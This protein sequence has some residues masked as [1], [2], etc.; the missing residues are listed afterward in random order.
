MKNGFFKHC[1]FQSPTSIPLPLFLL[2]RCQ[3]LLHQS[4][5]GIKAVVEVV[6]VQ[7]STALSAFRGPEKLR[8]QAVSNG[9]FQT[10]WLLASP[11]VAHGVGS[12]DV[13]NRY[14]CW[15]ERLP[16]KPRGFTNPYAGSPLRPVPM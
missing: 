8:F 7:C 6:D 9:L 4:P 1:C 5:I 16:I 2:F 13:D 14:K 11:L 10:L 12:K 3:P 15:A